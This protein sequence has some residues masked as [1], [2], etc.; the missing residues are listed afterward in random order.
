M[1]HIV[2]SIFLFS[3]CASQS[4]N[5]KR[6][7]S[8]VLETRALDAKFTVFAGPEMPAEVV[9]AKSLPHAPLKVELQKVDPRI[10]CTDSSDG[11][12]KESFLL[13]PNSKGSYAKITCRLTHSGSE[14]PEKLSLDAKLFVLLDE[15][16]I[17]AAEYTSK[18]T[19][20]EYQRILSAKEKWSPEMR[21]FIDGHLEVK[22]TPVD[23]KSSTPVLIAELGKEYYIDVRGFSGEFE[24]KAFLKKIRIGPQGKS[25]KAPK[26][27][28]PNYNELSLVCGLGVENGAI[29][30]VTNG[31]GELFQDT[32]GDKPY[33]CHVNKELKS[34]DEKKNS[35]NLVVQYKAITYDELKKLV[36]KFQKNEDSELEGRIK[37]YHNTEWKALT[38]FQQQLKAQMASWEGNLPKIVN[39]IDR[40]KF[41]KFK[42]TT[43]SKLFPA[44]VKGTVSRA[45]SVISLSP[46]RKLIFDEAN[47]EKYLLYLEVTNSIRYRIETPEFIE[48]IDREHPLEE[49]VKLY[50]ATAD[51]FDP[52]AR[53]LRL[54]VCED[55]LDDFYQALAKIQTDSNAATPALSEIVKPLSAFAVPSIADCKSTTKERAAITF[56]RGKESK[57]YLVQWKKGDGEKLEAVKVGATY[58]SDILG[59]QVQSQVLRDRAHAH[60]VFREGITIPLAEKHTPLW[61]EELGVY[62]LFYSDEKFI[63]ADDY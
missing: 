9:I 11:A 14:Y 1:R 15:F 18:K 30:T 6:H 38:D 4:L 32:H 24:T 31:A 2:F 29:K 50:L 48:K 39:R 27:V 19:L 60:P 34:S 42:D 59:E 28:Y 8:S 63:R 17:P 57:D 20:E 41:V 37:T 49:R 26:S 54:I 16:E 55:R 53:S 58:R 46:L 62:V 43:I 40:E 52:K 36:T 22:S 13:P 51:G 33:F 47:E 61:N 21:T 7:P 5:L 23:A 12:T 45:G 56:A 44:S 3:G 35:G 25:S 10:K